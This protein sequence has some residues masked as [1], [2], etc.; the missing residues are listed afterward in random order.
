[1]GYGFL[2]FEMTCD[3][4]QDNGRFIDDGRMKES[5]REIISIGFVICDEKYKIQRKYSTFIKPV[6]NTEL[7]D[8]CLNLTGIKQSDVDSGKKSNNAF[9]AICEL[10]KT[11]SVDRIYTYGSADQRAV[12]YSMKWNKKANEKVGNMYPIRDKI[13]DISPSIISAGNYK[14]LKKRPGLYRIASDLGLVNNQEAHNALNDAMMLY[15]VC[16]KLG[17]HFD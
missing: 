6:H 2:D 1:M 14:S 3:G 16:K 11:Y 10:C 8:Y 12:N 5:Q 17:I 7:S 13:I 15:R 9:R 4:I